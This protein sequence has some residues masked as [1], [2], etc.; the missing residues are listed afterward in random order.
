MK[1]LGKNQSVTTVRQVYD[2]HTEQYVMEAETKLRKVVKVRTNHEQ[3]RYASLYTGVVFSSRFEIP[4][5][6]LVEDYVFVR[7]MRQF[8]RDVRKA[9][10]MR[11]RRDRR[12]D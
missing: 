5:F 6:G 11:V 4:D 9:H 8:K 12:A 3:Y 7:K 1:M 2:R 10:G